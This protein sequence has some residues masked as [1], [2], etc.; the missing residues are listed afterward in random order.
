MSEAVVA[1]RYADALFQLASE[2]NNEEELVAELQVIQTV[3]Q[4]NQKL[5]D[6]LHHPRISGAEKMDLIN[7]AFGQF[8]K[9]V[10]NTLKILVQ[11]NRIR[12]VPS[13]IDHFV[14]LYNEAKGIAVATVYSV[15][16]SID[17]E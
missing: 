5:V 14:Y 11:R 17:E 12:L 7:E 10:L 2:K 15:S 9:D 16:E 6:L 4:N 13:I 8:H 3:F 1:K